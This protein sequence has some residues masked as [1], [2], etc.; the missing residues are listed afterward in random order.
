MTGKMLVAALVMGVA[1]AG[2]SV[3]SAQ[4]SLTVTLHVTDYTNL[5]RQDL[6]TAEAYAAAIYRA[7]GIETVWTDAPWG[8][9]NARSPHLRVAILLREMAENKSKGSGLGETAMG[10]G[11]D[12]EGAN[13]GSVAYIFYDR[14]VRAAMKNLTA[15]ERGLGYV[16]AHEVGHLLLG[17][18]S[19]SRTG[20]MSA[21]WDP[22]D[23]HVQILTVEQADVIRRRHATTKP[24]M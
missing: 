7:S 14:I 5:S 12:G 11:G 2:A 20:L 23:R 10:I 8:S 4:E 17:A 13:D 16:L 6:A 3:A 9:G 22:S 15:F 24:T 21:D 18:H 19:H 1:V